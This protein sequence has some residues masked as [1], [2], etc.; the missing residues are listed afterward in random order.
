M[1]TNR[2]EAAPPLEKRHPPTDRRMPKAAA[3]RVVRRRK[4]R[5]RMIQASPFRSLRTRATIPPLR[6]SG[7]WRSP[8]AHCNGVAG[9]AGSNPAVPIESAAVALAATAGVRSHPQPG[10]VLKGILIPLVCVAVAGCGGKADDR[11]A[12][13]PGFSASLGG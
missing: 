13:T 10:A 4:S 9:V 8:V 12:A 11:A 1:E 3:L 6:S 5:R 7:T 2:L